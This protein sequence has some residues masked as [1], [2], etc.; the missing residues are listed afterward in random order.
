[1]DFWRRKMSVEKDLIFQFSPAEQSRPNMGVCGIFRVI[2]L[3]VCSNCQTEAIYG[4]EILE[5]FPSKNRR[6]FE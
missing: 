2:F 5:S 4:K 6:N 1:M 3:R